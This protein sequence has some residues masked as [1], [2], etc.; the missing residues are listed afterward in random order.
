MKFKKEA[1][2]ATFLRDPASRVMSQ[3]RSD[4]A[5]LPD[6]FGACKSFDYLWSRA[7]RTC[8]K[9]GTQPV[10]YSDFATLMLGGCKWSGDKRA[11]CVSGLSTFLLIFLKI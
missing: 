3:W 8:L 2:F 10:Q 7:E 1:V 5:S 4:T 11:W 6:I 9:Q